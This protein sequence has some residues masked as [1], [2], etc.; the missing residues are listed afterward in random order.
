MPKKDLTKAERLLNEQMLAMLEWAADRPSIGTTS[1]SLRRR[2]AR[3]SCSQ[4]AA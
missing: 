3:P 1:A 2:S 4:S